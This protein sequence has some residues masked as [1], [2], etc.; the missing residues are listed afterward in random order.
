M[1]SGDLIFFFWRGG[2]LEWADLALEGW[3]GGLV[4]MAAVVWGKGGGFLDVGGRR[5]RES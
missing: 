4:L 5:N 3:G 2:L 1:E